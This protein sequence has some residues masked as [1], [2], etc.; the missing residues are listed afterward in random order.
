M[1]K[2]AIL[3][4][5][6]VEPSDVYPAPVAVTGLVWSKLMSPEDYVL[7]L[8]LSELEEGAQITW[9]EEHSDQ[10]VYV[11]SGGLEVGGHACPPRGAV[12]VESNVPAVATATSRSRIAHWGSWENAVPEQGLNGPLTEGEHRV[13]LIGP[14]GQNTSGDPNDVAVRSFANS[15]C[16]TCRISLFEVTRNKRRAGRPHSHSADEIIFL[17]DGTIELGSYKLRPG[18]SLCIP[19]GNRYAEGSGDDGAIFINYRREASDRTDFIKG[20]PPVTNP[21][22]RS[23]RDNRVDTN[24]VVDIAV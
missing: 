17:T 13:H 11:F 7:W 3:H 2:L 14:N 1:K 9:P 10:A 24:D 20:Q 23:A 12:I 16:D 22:A 19:G 18:T 15:A 4:E 5:D 21:E 6:E 8:C